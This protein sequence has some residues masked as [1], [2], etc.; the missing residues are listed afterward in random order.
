MQT[1]DPKEAQHLLR[2][3]PYEKWLLVGRMMVPKGVH[4]A[5]IASL[6]ELE[7]TIRPT[8]K[9]LVAMRLENLEWWLR[10]GVEDIALADRVSEIRSS[11][12]S[13]VEQSKAIYEAVLARVNLLRRAADGEVP[14]A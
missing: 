4:Q 14:H 8:A 9:T 5:R 10:E 13:Y 6:E 12:S 2:E 3:L 11:G 1:I 7:W